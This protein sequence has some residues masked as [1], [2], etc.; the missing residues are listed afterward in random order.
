[1]SEVKTLPV[2]PPHWTSVEALLQLFYPQFFDETNEQYVDPAILLQLATLAE[3]TRPWCLPPGQQDLAQAAFTAYLVSLRGET[4][5]GV[6]N[7]PTIGPIQSEKE[8]DIQ[9][10]YAASTTNTQSGMSQRPPS[11]AWDTWNRLYMRCAKGSIM[12]RFGD[13]CRSARALTDY[14]NPLAFNVWY[15][16][17]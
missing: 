10:T 11:D 9:V 15:P 6:T 2:E 17:W 13:P 5:S 8:G 1:V 14:I 3:E 7:V 4:S 12:T 16:I